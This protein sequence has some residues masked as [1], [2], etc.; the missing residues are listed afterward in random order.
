MLDPTQRNQ[1]KK[2]VLMR[3]YELYTTPLKLALMEL[4]T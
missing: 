2:I 4:P 1:N 3:I